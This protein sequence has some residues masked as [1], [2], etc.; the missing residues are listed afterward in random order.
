MTFNASKKTK[1]TNIPLNIDVKFANQEWQKTPK[2]Y[3][4]TKENNIESN[5]INNYY[6][7]TEKETILEQAPGTSNDSKEKINNNEIS[8]SDIVFVL[9]MSGTMKPGIEQA[10]ENLLT[11]YDSFQNSEIENQYSI[12]GYYYTEGQQKYKKI[13]FTKRRETLITETDKI[14]T[15]VENKN[16][17]EITL[18]AL[19]YTIYNSNFRENTNKVII[20]YTDELLSGNVNSTLELQCNLDSNDQNGI[21]YHFLNNKISLIYNSI[22]TRTNSEGNA[23]INIDQDL[24]EVAKLTHKYDNYPT[25]SDVIKIVEENSSTYKTII[26]TQKIY[27]K[28]KFTAKITTNIKTK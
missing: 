21:L 20:L 16:Y 24:Q 10:K 11:F 7:F 27:T 2:Y 1:F 13:N 28:Q 26:K 19:Y 17:N 14:I 6:K 8:D 15:I 5:E 9:D 4:K 23:I 12:I 25:L 3:N 18:D 22:S